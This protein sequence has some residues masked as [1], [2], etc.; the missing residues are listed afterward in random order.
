MKNCISFLHGEK[1]YFHLLKEK[2]L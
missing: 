2:Y 1:H